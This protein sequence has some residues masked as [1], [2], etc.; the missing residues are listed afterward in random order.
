MEKARK[1]SIIIPVYNSS[2]YLDK[3]IS[4]V[5]GQP[6]KDFELI[7]VDDGSTDDSPKICRKYEVKDSRIKVFH[8]ENGGH[9]S[10]RNY[11][12]FHSSGE[13]ILFLDS[14]DWLGEN[15][16]EICNK[17]IVENDPD[18]VIYNIVGHYAQDER[19]F[20]LN[21][22]DGIYYLND[23]KDPIKQMLFN[24]N[25]SQALCF[26][27]LAG[28]VFKK[29]I[30]LP[31]QLNIPDNISIGE[32]HISFVASMLDS[33]KI[34]VASS[35]NYNYF[36]RESSVSHKG[37]G[38]ALDKCL[39]FLT[40]YEK[41]VKSKGINIAEID[42]EV[43]KLTVLHAYIAVQ[44]LAKSGLNY[45]E[46][47]EK[48]KAFVSSTIVNARVKKARFDKSDKKMRLKQFIL[49]KRLLWLVGIIAKRNKKIFN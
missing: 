19:I 16:L 44:H 14:D 21:K 3:C 28:K 2:E 46:K 22:P 24:T 25:E 17:E 11:G 5:L 6:F 27:S 49:K 8:K 23:D 9:T 48:L 30:I 38:D 35:A 36:I 26:R 41:M 12:L 18:I 31:N 29:S 33:K 45:R 7:L 32:D 10:A 20:P 40:Y 1:F 47:K 34:S 4:T 43:N 37:D 42:N 13:Y 39:A 15:V